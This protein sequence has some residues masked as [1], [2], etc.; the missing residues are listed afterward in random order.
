VRSRPPTTRAF[1]TTVS[2]SPA[3]AEDAIRAALAERGFGVLTEIDVAATLKAK[4]GVERAPL[5]I[6]GACNPTF[7][8]RALEIDPSVALL[9][10]CNVAV[11][12]VDGGA[13]VSAVDPRALMD[14]PRF[15][16]LAAEVAAKLRDAV[17]AVREV[18]A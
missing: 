2:L 18:K 14:D 9:L 10:P 12:G 13:R 16:T 5:K 8:N 3:E 11:E 4:L 17:D 1:E 6:L 7:A 15:E